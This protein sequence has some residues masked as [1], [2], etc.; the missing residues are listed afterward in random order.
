MIQKI[1][2]SINY[3]TVMILKHIKSYSYMCM[4]INYLFKC[5][6]KWSV[7]NIF[8]LVFQ[9]RYLLAG[10]NGTLHLPVLDCI[11]F[12]KVSPLHKIKSCYNYYCS[13]QAARNFTLDFRNII[14][15]SMIEGYKKLK[16]IWSIIPSKTKRLSEEDDIHDNGKHNGQGLEHWDIERSSPWKAPCH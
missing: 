14:R 7:L 13:N 10:W 2:F 11:F 4:Y 3:S 8:R 12:Y 6:C 5:I 9:E 15:S 16:R 1:R